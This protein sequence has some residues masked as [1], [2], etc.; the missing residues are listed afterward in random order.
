[1]IK[2]A[3]AR[4]TLRPFFR[5]RAAARSSTV[6]QFQQGLAK[7]VARPGQPVAIPRALDQ[8]SG[9]QFAQVAAQGRGGNPRPRFQLAEPHL[10]SKQ[11]Q[12]LLSPWM[13]N[14]GQNFTDIVGRT[15]GLAKKFDDGF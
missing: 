1:M 6:G 2:Y 11:L 3:A 9:P 15:A 8:S 4:K 12:D 5:K 10:A 14:A 13:C 7:R